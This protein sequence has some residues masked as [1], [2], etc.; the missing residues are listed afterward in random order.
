MAKKEAKTQKSQIVAF[1]VEEDLA[2]FLDKLPNKSE[3]IRKAIL[4]QFGMTC[5]LCTGSGV[6]PRHP[7]TLSTSD[8]RA[9]PAAVREVQERCDRADVRGGGAGGRS[10]PLRTVPARRAAVLR[11]VL[12]HDH[13]LRRLRLARVHGED[14]GPL[15]ESARPLNVGD[16]TAVTTP[17]GTLIPA[18]ETGFGLRAIAANASSVMSFSCVPPRCITAFTSAKLFK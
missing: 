8:R 5:P 3:F 15:Q 10:S 12:P 4:A 1:K 13:I 18:T 17:T 11:Q 9:Q 14:G 7:R 6:V 16:H 2:D